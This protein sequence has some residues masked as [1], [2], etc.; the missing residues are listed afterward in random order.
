MIARKSTFAFSA[1]MFNIFLGYIA[2]FFIAHYMG[3]TAI[4]M[5][6]FAVAFVGMFSS[7]ADLGFGAAHVKRISEGKDLGKCNGTY[8]AVTTFLTAI[9]TIAVLGWLFISKS[10]FHT[11]FDPEQEIMIYIILVSTT[12]YRF[13]LVGVMTFGARKEI[14]KQQIPTIFGSVVQVSAKVIVAVTGLSVIFLAGANLLGTLVAFIAF[15]FL[16]RSYPISRPNKEYLKSYL[17]FAMPMMFIMVLFT[18]SANLDKVMIQS[19]C[20]IEDVGYYTAPQSISFVLVA[21]ASSVSA[22][23]FPTISEYHSKGNIDSIRNLSSVAERYISMLC[24]PIVAFVIVFAE[25]TI[26]F[27]LSDRFLPSI[28][29]LRILIVVAFVNAITQPYSMQIG[30]TDRIKLSAKISVVVLL[31]N[32][33]LNFLLIPQALFGVKLIGLGAAGAAIA[34]LIAMS[35]GT[36]LFRFASYKVTGT[37]Q[38]WR[39]LIHLF[40]A[41]AMGLSMYFVNTIFPITRWYHLVG[42]GLLSIVIYFGVLFVVKEFKKED[43]KFFM[44][45]VNP[46]KMNEYVEEELK[47]R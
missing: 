36:V 7:I 15:F 3:P 37:R 33:L 22:L 41:G 4:G 47:R 14:A 1:Q 30:G 32:I 11:D 31:T 19:F 12:I 28:S 26:H 6:G 39:I 8:L 18:L 40:A 2:L 24:I 16:F 25:P 13:S 5:L 45:T 9:M 38:N 21:L 17:A 27:L 42:Y 20:S 29:L 34:T 44:D 35:I 23:L 43:F 10:V 46:R